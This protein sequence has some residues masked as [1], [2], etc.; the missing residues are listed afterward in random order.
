MANRR[1]IGGIVLFSALVSAVSASAPDD[2]DPFCSNGLT[3]PRVH[4]PNT[5]FLLDSYNYINLLPPHDGAVWQQVD[6]DDNNE[7]GRGTSVSMSSLVHMNSIA[8]DPA[9]RYIIPSE[10]RLYSSPML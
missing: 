3:Y 8:R 2:V 10:A 4:P 5:R 1:S 6:N 7:A 9:V